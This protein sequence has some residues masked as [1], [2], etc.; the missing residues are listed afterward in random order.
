MGTIPVPVALTQTTAYV[1]E[2]AGSSELLPARSNEVTVVAS[3][4]AR[5][6]ISPVRVPPGSQSGRKMRL[7][8]RGAP[9]LKGGAQGDLYLTLQIK[10][11][12]DADAQAREAAEALARLYRG[13]VR[14]ELK[15]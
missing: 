14:G 10:V 4:P 2:L 7:K 1:I 9:S 6:A 15:L 8:G 11:P 5:L 13:D 12:E 3:A